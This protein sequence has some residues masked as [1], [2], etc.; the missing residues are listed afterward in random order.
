MTLTYISICIHID[1]NT[2]I[3]WVL[4]IVHRWIGVRCDTGQITYILIYIYTFFYLF[5]SLP[6]PLYSCLCL[7][8]IN[9]S[10]F[11]FSSSSWRSS[12]ECESW[13][14]QND[15][16]NWGERIF[17]FQAQQQK[18]HHVSMFGTHNE[19]KKTPAFV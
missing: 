7:D 2:Y 6:L 3:F 9:I 17:F 13:W 5:C 14:F 19:E 18:Q 12:I 1:T 16:M 4:A 8:N 15:R 11:I 10:S